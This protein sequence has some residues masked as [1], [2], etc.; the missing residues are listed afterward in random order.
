M[1]IVIFLLIVVIVS[2]EACYLLAK[3]RGANVAYWIVMGACFGPLAIP[4]ALF[5]KP[6]KKPP[7]V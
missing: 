6:K 7:R 2:A 5:A 3:R 1:N 4:F